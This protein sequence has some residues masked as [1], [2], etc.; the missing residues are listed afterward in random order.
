MMAKLIRA[1]AQPIAAVLKEP[2]RK[3]EALGALLVLGLFNGY[4]LANIHWLA[5]QS[6]LETGFWTNRGTQEDNNIFGMSRVRVRETTQTGWRRINELETSGVYGSI[7]S[8]VADRFM[9][10]RH[11]DVVAFRRSEQYAEKVCEVY[12]AAPSY[13]SSVGSTSVSSYRAIQGAWSVVIP[14]EAAL[15]LQILKK[16]LL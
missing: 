12:H 16:Y 7:W 5:K 10:D 8:C 6:A 2:A 15:V 13:C 3:V 9:W 4:S 11:F 14:V 1:T